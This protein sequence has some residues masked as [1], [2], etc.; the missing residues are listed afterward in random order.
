MNWNEYVK[1]KG[2]PNWPYPIRYGREQ[3]I[4][5]EV[6]VLGGGIAGCWAAI[7]AARQGI[8]VAMVEKGATV[9]SGAGGTGC[10][11]WINTPHP[12]SAITAEEVVQSE[13]EFTGGFTN[14]ISRYI[15]ARESYE[16]LLEL[17]QMGGKIRDSENHFKGAPFRDDE[18]KFLFAYDY[19]N[20][21]HF[22][23]WGSTFKPVL[24]KACKKAGVEIF[25]RVMIYGLLTENGEIG[26]KVVGAT[27]LHSRTGE[28]LVFKA[29]AI[30]D[31]MSRHQRN[32]CF[33]SELRGLSSFR[34]PTIVGDGHA[35]AWRAGA[36]FAMMEKSMP[37]SFGSGNVFPPYGH[38][39]AIN[40]WFP[41]NMVDAGG[42]PIPYVDRDGKI[43]ET[44]LGRSMPA[45]NQRFMGERTTAY[46]HKRP[47]L[48]PDLEKRIR[49]GEFS[50][51]LYADLSSM[52]QYESEVI[53]GMMVGE[54]G[55]TKVPILQTYAESG[56][57]PAKDQLQSYLFLGGDPMRGSVRPQDRTGGEI[58]DAGGLMVDWDLRTN[59]EGLYAAGDALFAGNYHYHAAATGRYAGRKAATYARATTLPPLSPQQVADQK[60]KIYAPLENSQDIEWKEVNAA[61]CRVMQNYCGE[62]KNEE[63]LKIGLIWLEDI[64][65][66][67][68]SRVCVDNPHK[69][70]RTLEVH[71]ILTCSEMI[72]HAS[73][74]RR[75][76]NPHL[77]F[78]RQDYPQTDSPDGH[79]W[80][81][82]G[83]T[84]GG[85]KSETVPI[86]FWSP[87]VENYERHR[88]T[89]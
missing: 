50:L 12:G 18:T 49:Q 74:E 57:D 54:E 4:D 37:T 22:R 65:I 17:E 82:I 59:L 87:M 29:K 7:S 48:I 68:A 85:I 46:T 78:F 43:I 11:H 64:K 24:Y 76:S 26:N 86:D 45:P 66:N 5:T 88:R 72:V 42:K 51:P 63:L 70:M 8:K 61:I 32:W 89:R 9:S 13:L 41:C 77:G 1:Q 28:F 15:A 10:D 44:E 21:I 79:K 30:I 33:S 84:E 58:G 40:T 16:T 81:T 19:E 53:W 47:E 73:L 31:C 6:L 67:E 14:G 36:K 2:V 25:D 69:L 55:K 27:G 60:T 56:F 83:L 52:S 34:P 38:G 20:R 80:V 39:N 75:S 62:I 35:A 23:V 3:T 71:N